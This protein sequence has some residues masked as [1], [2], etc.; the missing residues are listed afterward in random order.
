M[1]IFKKIK[2]YYAIKKGKENEREKRGRR[3]QRIIKIK[4]FRK[5]REVIFIFLF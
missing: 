4:P 1:K 3:R 2:T 5:N